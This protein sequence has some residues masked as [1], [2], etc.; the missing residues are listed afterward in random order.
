MCTLLCSII[1]ISVQEAENIILQHAQSPAAENVPLEEAVG[2]VLCASLCADRDFPPYDRVTMDGVALAF[3]SWAEG[4]RSFTVQSVAAAGHPHQTLNSADGCVEVM[5]GAMLPRG[6]D[7]VVRYEDL[8]IGDQT[9][10]I[11]ESVSLKHGQNV[12]KQGS[13]RLKNE[14]LLK[15][16]CRLGTAEIA[17]AATIGAAVLPVRQRPAVAIVST[18][19]ELVKVGATPLPHQIRT[20]NSHAI[21][22]LL[23]QQWGLPCR[24]FHFSDDPVELQT[25]LA[26]LLEGYDILILSGAVSEG[27]FDHVPTVLQTLGVHRQFHKVAQRPG[28]PFW[29]GTYG[30]QKTV[31]ALPGNPVSALLCCCRYILPFL[32]KSMGTTRPRWPEMLRLGETV[33]FQP[34]LTCFIPCFIKDDPRGYP[35]AFPMPG[36]GSGDLANLTE[37]DGFLE[38]PPDRTLF[39]QGEVFHFY[40]YRSPL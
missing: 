14:V 8:N 30:A 34:A 35:L 29:F 15:A 40:P 33:S 10:R 22:A 37:A 28:K 25:G 2:R 17:V 20:S 6:A 31:F 23:Q 24:L 13:D 3:S 7:T 16:G 9:V 4:R 27:K 38:L 1:V 19:D 36:H 11:V 18:G 39:A 32:Q 12:H 5:T 21:A 26:A